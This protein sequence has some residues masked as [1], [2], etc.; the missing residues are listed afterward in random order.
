MPR[1]RPKKVVEVP[2]TELEM[3]VAQ[4]LRLHCTIPGCSF[5]YHLEE[6]KGVIKIIQGENK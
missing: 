5:K 2:P 1:G 6:A 3:Q 4:Y